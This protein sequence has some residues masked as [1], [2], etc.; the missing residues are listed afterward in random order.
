MRLQQ[1]LADTSW[2]ATQGRLPVL[3]QDA[4]LHP[5]VQDALDRHAH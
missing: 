1:P 5:V 3:D 2:A 4:P